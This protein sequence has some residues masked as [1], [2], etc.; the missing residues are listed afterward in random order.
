MAPRLALRV[1]VLDPT[2]SNLVLPSPT[3]VRN[4]RTVPVYAFWAWQRLSSSSSSS[5]GRSLV[6]GHGKPERLR[7][8]ATEQLSRPVGIY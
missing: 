8:L 2:E 7:P 3:L 1:A 6:R 4:L 5:A